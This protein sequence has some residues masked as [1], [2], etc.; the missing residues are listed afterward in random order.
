[1]VREMKTFAEAGRRDRTAR[2]ERDC[3]RAFAYFSILPAGS[4]RGAARGRVG[5]LPLVGIVVGALA[6]TLGVAGEFGVARA[7][8]RG[9][10]VR[11]RTSC[12]P[13]RSTSTGSSMRATRCSRRVPPERR[14]AILKDPHHGSFALAG[15]RSSCAAWLAALAA[16][17]PARMAVGVGILRRDGAGALRCCNAFRLSVCGRRHRRRRHSSAGPAPRALFAPRR[18]GLGRLRGAS[19]VAGRAGAGRRPSSRSGSARGARAGS[20]ACSS[21]TVMAR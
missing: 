3:A 8:G 21:A 7:A 1:M 18:A 16:I 17:P 14:L 4:R 12:S 11:R 19:P 9:R 6:G 13:A 2:R 10:S 15:L 5:W 20:T